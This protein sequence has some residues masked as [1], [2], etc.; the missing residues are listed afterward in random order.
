[1]REEILREI[2]RERK[3][4]TII[5]L[6]ANG[7]MPDLVFVNVKGARNRFGG[8]DSVRQGIDSWAP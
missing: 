7:V 3:E 5:A 8:I 1:L 4:V 6:F 2:G